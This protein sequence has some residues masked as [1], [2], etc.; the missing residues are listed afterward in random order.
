M[1]Q[2]VSQQSLAVIEKATYKLCMYKQ[3]DGLQG[4]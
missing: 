3:E 4:A 1:H 2:N